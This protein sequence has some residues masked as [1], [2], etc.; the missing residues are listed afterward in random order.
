M[1]RSKTTLLERLSQ[2]HYAF[3]DPAATEG[4]AAFLGISLAA[5]AAYPDKLA[6]TPGLLFEDHLEPMLQAHRATLPAA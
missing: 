3:A 4:L 5:E 6:G 2:G 1:V